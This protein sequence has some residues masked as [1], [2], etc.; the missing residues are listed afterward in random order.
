MPGRHFTSPSAF[1]ARFADRA[2][3]THARVVRTIE[4]RPVGLIDADRAAMLIPPPVARP[5]GGSTG[6]GQHAATT[7]VPTAATTP[8]TLR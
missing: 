4:T 2:A 1:D 3:I 7:S 6:S 8:W 5:S